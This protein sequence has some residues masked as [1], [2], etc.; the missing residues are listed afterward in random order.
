MKHCD[1]II[2]GAGAAGLSAA[3]VALRRGRSVAILDMGDRPARKVA[4]SGGGRCNFTNDAVAYTRYHGENPEF[5]RSAI[6]RT[7]PGDILA[8]A[9]AH[10]IEF[11]E[12][13]P[14]QYFCADGANKI[15]DALI[16]DA[17]EAD[18]VMSATVDTITKEND[19]FHVHAGADIRTA[20]SVIVATGGISFPALGVSDAGYKIAR[21]FGHK[22][23]PPQPALC[24]LNMR[25]FPPELAG[26]S[27]PACISVGA[28]EINDDL[29]LTHAGIGGPA[30]YRA[31]I[32][33]LSNGIYINLMPGTDVV[34]FLRGARRTMARKSISGVLETRMPA[35]LAKWITG[36]V[37]KNMAD[38]SDVEIRNI[39]ERI[40]HIF[41]PGDQI[42]RH[43]M[44]GAEVVRGGVSTDA[45]S[46]KTM[47]S[48]LCPGLF[49]AGEVLD[50][51]GD[52]GGF[53]L[54]W[55]WASGR[56]AGENA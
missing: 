10:N 22:I 19:L 46:S 39:A 48:K 44:S 27:V 17:A 35:R 5:V 43:G 25:Y 8:W 29:L 40:S 49:W 15:V 7:T 28:A 50:I 42:T 23:V 56:A 20:Q 6:A 36:G 53:N 31:S 52:L 24:A 4:V 21:Q 3:A 37:Q 12:K 33:N 16:H 2:I 45:V 9:T 30:A 13:A 14:G 1:I 41:I 18:F 34:E 54:H 55:A 26:I 11:V 32:Y 38:W 51:A 47:E